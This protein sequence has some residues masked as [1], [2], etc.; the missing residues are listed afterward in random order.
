MQKQ[1]KLH[2]LLL[3]SLLILGRSGVSGAQE[4]CES[5]AQIIS[6]QG[7]IR[8]NKILI[9]NATASRNQLTVCVGDTISAGQLSRAAI[10]IFDTETVIRIDQNTEL[11]LTSPPAKDPSFLE[12]FKRTCE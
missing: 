6:A 5:V 7:E 2:W 11:R 8:V 3:I 12:L 9:D 10:A 4:A 1:Q